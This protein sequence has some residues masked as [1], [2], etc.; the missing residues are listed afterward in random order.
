MQHPFVVGQAMGAGF[1][2]A[3]LGAA[4]LTTVAIE[5]SKWMLPPEPRP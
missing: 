3:V 2:L 1:V 5:A 4:V